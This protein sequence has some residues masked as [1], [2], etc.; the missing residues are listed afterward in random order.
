MPKVIAFPEPCGIIWTFWGKCVPL[1]N[2][3]QISTLIRNSDAKAKPKSVILNLSVQYDIWERINTLAN[4]LGV[5]DQDLCRI[6]LANGINAAA[7]IKPP[8]A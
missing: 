5:S 6:F 4:G 3:P 8:S 7:P 2:N 1:C